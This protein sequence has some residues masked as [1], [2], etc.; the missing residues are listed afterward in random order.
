M[1][2]I[3]RRG[4]MDE[5]RGEVTRLLSAWNDSDEAREKLWALLY[6]ELKDLARGVAR[7]QRRVAQPTS[8]VHK[9]YLRL[10]D[11]EVIWSDRRHFFAVAARAMRFVLA[12]EAR[13]QLAQKRGSGEVSSLEDGLSNMADPAAF[14][15]EEVL[16]VHQALER[17]A[18]I[19]P[20]HERVVELRYFAG[21]SVNETAELLEVEPRTI[22]RDWKAIKIWLHGELAVGREHGQG[23]PL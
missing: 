21:L 18:E 10:L 23:A 22:V 14:R 2:R 13:R 15:P 8:L 9:A 11:S 3:G 19:R 17:L 4:G 20:R 1:V 6:Q 16:A 5:R 12:D 7:G